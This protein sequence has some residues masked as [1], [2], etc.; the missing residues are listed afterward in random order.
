MFQLAVDLEAQPARERRT[1]SWSGEVMFSNRRVEKFDDRAPELLQAL[2]DNPRVQQ[3][4]GKIRTPT[5]R[6]QAGAE[7]EGVQRPRRALRGACC[8]ASRSTRRWSRSAR[9]IAIGAAR[10]PSIAA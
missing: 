1:P 8:T 3:I 2:A 7:D 5:R 4:R 10:S 6:R 9:R